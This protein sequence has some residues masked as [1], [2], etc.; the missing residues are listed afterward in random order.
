VDF[1]IVLVELFLLGVMAEALQ[2]KIDWKLAF[3]KRVGQYL[4]NFCERS[5]IHG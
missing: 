2:V 1:L 5:F 4:P 3:Y